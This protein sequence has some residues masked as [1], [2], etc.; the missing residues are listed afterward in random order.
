M[1]DDKLITLIS[2]VLKLAPGRVTDELTM[3]QVECWD[4]LKHME[5]VVAIET[6]YGLELSFDEIVTMKS[7]GDIRRVLAAR[8]KD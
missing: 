1:N 6:G 8:S 5:L 3:G 7:V 2:D 4:S